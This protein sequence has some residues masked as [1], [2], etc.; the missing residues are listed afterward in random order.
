MIAP[1]IVLTCAHNAYDR[2]RKQEGTDI[3]FA[4]RIN[5]KKGKSYKVKELRYPEK[6]KTEENKSNDDFCVMELEES[7][8]N[9]G[10]LSIDFR[11]ENIEGM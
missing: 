3:I 10:Y 2:E 11:K 5:G 7:L 6:F 8:E 4:P 9:I 1:N